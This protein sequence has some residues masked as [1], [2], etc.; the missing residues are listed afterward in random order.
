MVGRNKLNGTTFGSNEALEVK[1][2]CGMAITT[3]A[4]A[5]ANIVHG[6]TSV[7]TTTTCKVRCERV[8]TFADA[9]GETR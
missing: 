9:K 2:G 6:E 5:N 8:Q 3:T 1:S 4:I 7:G